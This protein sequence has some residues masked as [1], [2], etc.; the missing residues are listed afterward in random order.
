MYR[1]IKHIHL[2]GVGGIGMSGIA[3]LLHLHGYLVSGSDVT[4]NDSIKRLES[5]GVRI[6]LG[7][8]AGNISGAE[9]VVFSSAIGP[10]NPELVAARDLAIPVITRAEMLVEL[11][12]VKYGIA[13]AGAHG[14]TTTT[15]MVALILTRAGL[16]PTVVVGGRMDNFGGT[17]SR[18]GSGEFMVVEADESDGS[19]TR[20]T[21]S[22]SVITNIDREHLDYYKDLK[23]LEEAFLT[24]ANHVPF[25][26]LTVYCED[27]ATLGALSKRMPM[28]KVNYGFSDKA[29]YRASGYTVH[30]EHTVCDLNVDG[31]KLKIQL[32]VPGRHN[33]LNSLAALAVA[34]ELSIPRSGSIESLSLFQGVQRR[35]QKRGERNGVLFIDDYA[36]H[37]TEIM[38]TLSTVRERYPCS[39]V[40]VVFQPHR[41]SRVEDLFDRFVASF[42]QCDGVA[43]TDIYAAGEQ[44][45]VGIDSTRIVEGLRRRGLENSH[46]VSRPLEAVESLLMQS[47]LGDIIIT[48]GAGDLPNV[49]KHLW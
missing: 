25:Y 32:R 47:G 12:R 43:V 33:V 34:D 18:L 49:Y 8:A 40:R 1:K 20:I 13:V 35:F 7:H 16:D 36:H 14:K 3:D 4:R 2:V 19:F 21:P 22:I 15:S 44:P 48:L 41:Y 27:D 10:S 29:R 28:R 6:Y 45:I 37:P 11:M 5:F 38:A 26:G 9:L 42:D 39:K 30:E 31:E 23:K 46:Y 24:F 17:N